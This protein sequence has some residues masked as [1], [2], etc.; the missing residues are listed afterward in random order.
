MPKQFSSK[1]LTVLR[2]PTDGAAGVGVFEHTDD[3]SIFHY[4]K[5]PDRVPGKG[6]AIARM[7][8]FNFELLHSRGIPTHFRHFHQPNR[9]EF[10]LLRI[11]NPDIRAIGENE[12]FYMIPL[13]VVYRNSLP[14]GASVFRRLET[15]SMT[16]DQLGLSQRPSPNQQLRQ[17]LIEFTTKR[18]EI[19]RFVTEEEARQ[20]AGLRPQ[21]VRR[22]KDLVLEINALISAHAESVGLQHADGKVEFGMYAPGEIVLVD[23]V[24]TADENRFL[25]DGRHV[26][27]Q[28]MRDYYLEQGLETDVQRWAAEGLPRES[29]PDPEPLP[30]GFLDPISA[31][32][33]ALTERWIG[34]SVWGTPP[35]EE[36]VDTVHLLTSPAVR[37]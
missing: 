25:Y 3:Y 10:S 28:I 33:R 19:D 24:G 13:Q 7:A 15:G 17:P 5:M 14:P 18:E 2:E 22:I 37:W 4:G 21:D 16:L 35:L 8:A 1:S 29:W 36:V 30:P 32:Y 11:L 9:V 31:M 20:L 12:G 26:G 27:K 6:E 23:N 34:E